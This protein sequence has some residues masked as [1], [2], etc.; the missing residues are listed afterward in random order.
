M[1]LLDLQVYRVASPA[2][3][4]NYFLFTSVDGAVRDPNEQNFLSTY[5]SA[6]NA[7]L[8]AGGLSSLF[9]LQE[10]LQEYRDKHPF[11]LLFGLVTMPMMISEATD[12]PESNEFL[13]L[14]E[15]NAGMT[16]WRSKMD[17]LLKSNPLLRPRLLA[18]LDHMIE[19][20]VIV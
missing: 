4:L 11:G 20:G 8:E 12:I 17:G 3:D 5:H 15:S 1:I 14:D 7:V 16:K 9:N 19:V 10:L 6:F 13:S 18:L 2:T